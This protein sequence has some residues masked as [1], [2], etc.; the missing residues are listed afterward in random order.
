MLL[1]SIKFHNFRP[2]IGD[3]E[4]DLSIDTD[5]RDKNV[6]I[7]LG[8][9]TFGKS[10][11]VL[12]FIWCLYGKNQFSKQDILNKKVEE[13]LP[14]DS[15]TK[16]FAFVEI[17]FEDDD[18]LYIMRRIQ[19]FYKNSKGELVASDPVPTLSYTT[20]DGTT[21]SAGNTSSEIN[22]VIKSILPADLS[23]FFFFE[24]EKNN[25]ITRKDLGTSVKTLLGLEAFNNM[26]NHLHGDNATHAPSTGSVMGHFK[27]QQGVGNNDKATAELE[28]KTNA[29]NKLEEIKEKLAEDDESIARCEKTIEGLN[30][31]LREAAPTKRMQERRDNIERELVSINQDLQKKTQRFFS[32]FSKDSFPFLVY[33]LLDRAQ[34]KL[35]QMDVGDKGIKGIEAPAIREL[36]RRGECL[37]GCDLTEGSAAYKNVE[38][39]LDY[40]PPRNLGTIVRDISDTISEEKGRAEDFVEMFDSA[41][42]DIVSLRIRKENLEKEEAAISAQI[43]EI[44]EVDTQ[45]AEEDLSYNKHL[46]TE[47]RDK[48][49]EAIQRIARLSQDIEIAN[50]NYDSLLSKNANARKYETY[51]KYAELIYEWVEKNYSTKEEQLK[52]RLSKYISESFNAMYSGHRD[53]SIDDRYNLVMT[54]NNAVVDD[55]GGLRVIEYFA[56]VGGLVKLAGEIKKERET[57]DEG[58]V[59]TLGE[60]YPLVLDAAFSHADE[61]HTRNIAQELS[62]CAN[63]L[64]FAIMRKDWVYAESGLNGKVGHM[65]ELE[66]VDETE[67]HI[68]EV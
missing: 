40:I 43:K 58:N 4:V 65:Y 13:L 29:E 3:Q 42:K 17:E 36:L 8:D 30:L 46:L 26:R 22:L 62:K 16:E 31:Q 54:Y 56:Y 19:S 21:R 32:L 35:A 7:I 48:H 37:C 15:K 14:A 11:F 33:P 2:F 18:K 59:E 55:T 66:K 68:K 44:G 64:I 47:L 38:K 24:G 28:K 61:K 23:S 34:D 51:Y 53:V 39:Y 20:P 27:K 12:S 50:K 25:E 60:E 10:T 57:D 49:D 67:V 63:Q 9:N 41:Y 52:E 45:Q 1:K 5:N 6:T